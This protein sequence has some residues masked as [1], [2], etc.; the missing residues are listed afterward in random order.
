MDRI[1]LTIVGVLIGFFLAEPI[2]IILKK[3]EMNFRTPILRTYILEKQNTK[4]Y[5]LNKILRCDYKYILTYSKVADG[6]LEPVFHLVENKQ[7]IR[8]ADNGTAFGMTFSNEA[9][10]AVLNIRYM[11]LPNNTY[12]E[13]TDKSMLTMLQDGKGIGILCSM[14]DIP[15]SFSGLLYYLRNKELCYRANNANA[16]II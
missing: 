13:I 16:W 1:L 12:F 6:T 11:Q 4:K 8:F 2:K 3:G 7:C 14:A 9:P 5:Y 10:N 15:K